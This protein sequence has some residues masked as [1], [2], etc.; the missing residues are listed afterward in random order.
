MMINSIF[1]HDNYLS[2]ALDAAW[3]R[4]GVISNNISN[5]DTPDFKASK[6]E[7]ESLL[8]MAI[9]GEDLDMK[10]TRSKHLKGG[11][12]IEDIEPI[13]TK[14][15][16]TTIRMDGNNVDMNTEQAE[17][18]QNTIRYYTL[19]QK[20]SEDLARLRYVIEAK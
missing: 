16:E 3:T 6:V 15:V 7:F 9:S 2:K 10:K 17:L 5:H 4:D 18:A 8:K 14:D 12:L 1:E 19:T 20:I 11:T 13:V